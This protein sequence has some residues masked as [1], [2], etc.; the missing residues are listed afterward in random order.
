MDK[1]VD[2]SKP[3]RVEEGGNTTVYLGRVDMKVDP[4]STQPVSRKEQP[5]V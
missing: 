1:N 3:H 5:H 4:R 2:T